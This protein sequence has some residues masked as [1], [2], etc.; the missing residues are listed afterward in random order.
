MVLENKLSFKVLKIR[1][2][3]GIFGKWVAIIRNYGLYGVFLYLLWFRE[4]FQLDC[5]LKVN[6]GLDV[7]VII[8]EQ[9]GYIFSLG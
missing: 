9:F 4:D 8:K 7:E 6:L 2:S 3:W 5:D 1:E